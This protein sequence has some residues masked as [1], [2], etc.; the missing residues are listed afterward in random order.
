MIVVLGLFEPLQHVWP[1]SFL[2][3]YSSGVTHHDVNAF[4][5]VLGPTDGL[6]VFRC[7]RAFPD[8]LTGARV[9]QG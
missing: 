8:I 3:G 6:L 2:V 1:V 9:G 7:L 5:Y 4:T